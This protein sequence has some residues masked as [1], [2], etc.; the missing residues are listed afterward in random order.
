M[1]RANDGGSGYQD[2]SINAQL[3]ADRQKG[4]LAAQLSRIV[5]LNKLFADG[6]I[7]M[8]DVTPEYDP[9][10]RPGRNEDSQGQ[11]SG[12]GG[13]QGRQRRPGQLPQP[14]DDPGDQEAGM[15]A[16][17]Q[18]GDYPTMEPEKFMDLYLKGAELPDFEKYEN[19]RMI[20]AS[21][22]KR[23]GEVEEGSIANIHREA[24]ILRKQKRILAYRA[25]HPGHLPAGPLSKIDMR[26][27]PWRKDDFRYQRIIVKDNPNS[28]IDAY[29][30]MD[31]SGSTSGT[32]LQLFKNAF[33]VFKRFLDVK[34]RGRDVRIFLYVHTT[35]PKP[36]STV[37][38]FLHIDSSGGTAFVSSIKA[39][40]AHARA[41]T[42]KR[43][44]RET[45]FF[46]C[47]DGDT[48]ATEKD[49]LTKQ[50]EEMVIDGFNHCFYLEQKPGVY[51]PWSIGGQAVMAVK[52]E[53]IKRHISTARITTEEQL[54]P[55]YLEWLKP[56]KR[57][58]RSGYRRRKAA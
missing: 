3:L 47:T 11:G 35:E 15:E 32:P 6:P 57:S 4:Q 48:P 55:I 28:A 18:E 21:K 39:I 5:N 58:G 25:T 46:H 37:E 17:D 8:V 13:Q 40:R 2:G 20:R 33:F 56:R 9:R 7:R 14:G 49:L 23:R 43:G 29:L 45:F 10:Y 36:V 12:T 50:Y 31:V 24:T 38:E 52:D 1:P 51:S 54:Q 44:L 22:Y 42:R 53:K 19:S 30:L 41:Q 34:Y 26:T 27:M 16:G